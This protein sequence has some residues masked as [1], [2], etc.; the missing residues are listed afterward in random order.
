MTASGT[1][2]LGPRLGPPVAWS[3]VLAGGLLIAAMVAPLVLKAI[4]SIAPE[5]G[6]TLSRVFNRVAMLAAIW[7][8][9][10]FR[11]HLGWPELRRLL[12][13]GKWRQRAGEVGIGLAAALLVIAV[14]VAWAFATHHLGPTLNEYH[15]FSQRTA[16]TLV[17]SL[18]A[19][20]IEESFF[21]G[22]MLASLTVSVGW[23]PAA[24]TSS[25]VYAS[26]HLLSSDRSFVWDGTSVGVGLAY[27]VHAV[28]RQ[29]EPQAMPP[30]LGLFLGGLV[31]AIVVRV[32]GSLYLVVGLHAGWIICFQ[33]IRHATRVIGEISGTSL[34]ATRHFLVGT[35]WAWVVI[36]LSGVV[37]IAVVRLTEGVSR[38][39][40]ATVSRTSA[41]R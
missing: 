39:E 14:G 17:G 40:S 28:G 20:L 3:A 18:V 15:F 31:L 4:C 5:T 22:L 2:G 19:A 38:S 34:L 21:R 7:M 13:R 24:L 11:R 6:L 25:A 8:L 12:G 41:G 36:V 32:T 35:G 9:I 37:A 26:V 33:V 23:W 27:L 16:T 30:L 1:G 10:A 29:L